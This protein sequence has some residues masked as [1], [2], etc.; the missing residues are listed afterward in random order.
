MS[1]TKTSFDFSLLTI[2]RASNVHFWVRCPVCDVLYPVV[3]PAVS[4]L[5]AEGWSFRCP[6]ESPSHFQID[7]FSRGVM[8]VRGD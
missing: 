5:S 3:I 4:I 6:V 1:L 7:I 2:H 8:F